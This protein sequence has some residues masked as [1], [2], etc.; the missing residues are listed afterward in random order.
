[1]VLALVLLPCLYRQLAPML[2]LVLILVLLLMPAL[3]SQHTNSTP[4]LQ[5]SELA[6]LS[7]QGP[8]HWLL[9]TDLPMAQIQPPDA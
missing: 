3:Y 5:V 6:Q 4:A 8:P 1:M 2:L 7:H 9:V